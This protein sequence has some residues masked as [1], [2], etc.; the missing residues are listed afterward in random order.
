M[1][2]E[3]FSRRGD[4]MHATFALDCGD[5]LQSPTRLRYGTSDEVF[6]PMQ[7]FARLRTVRGPSGPGQVESLPLAEIG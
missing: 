4:G 2:E 1:T 7:R 5:A 3:A 6:R